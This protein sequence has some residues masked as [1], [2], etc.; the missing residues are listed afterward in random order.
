M[1]KLWQKIVAGLAVLAVA[2]GISLW[3]KL[4]AVKAQP[5]WITGDPGNRYFYG[6]VGAGKTPGIPYWVWLVMP[7]VFPEEVQKPGGYAALGS[8]W[9][10]TREMP[11][12]L[13]KQQVGYVRV[14]GNCA[15]CHV[16]TVPTV[17]GQAPKILRAVAGKTND[18]QPLLDFFRNSANDPRF[19][20]GELLSEIEKATTLSLW[21]KALY[22]FV[23]IPCIRKE[24]REDP[25]KVIFSP[26][27][28]A[29]AQHPHVPF[30][31]PDLKALADYVRQQSEHPD[32]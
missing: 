10:E 1:K 24:M 3:Y 12:G 19:T 8:A 26:A 30:E 27:L 20:S 23:L 2:I 28:L 16:M 9:E 11:V 4:C 29:H 17:P 7:R 5:S 25:A 31:D 6:S 32:Q 18:P 21:D 22:R 13:A 14:T 15:L